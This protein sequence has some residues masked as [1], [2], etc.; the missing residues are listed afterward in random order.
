MKISITCFISFI[1]YKFLKKKQGARDLAQQLKAHMSEKE[2][3]LLLSTLYQVFCFN[4]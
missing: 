2:P 4:H 3:F 1:G